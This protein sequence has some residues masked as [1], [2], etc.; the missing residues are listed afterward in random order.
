[1]PVTVKTLPLKGT[2]GIPSVGLGTWQ[3]EKGAVKKAVAY[4]ELAFP[5]FSSFSRERCMC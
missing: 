5:L 3:S 1:M 2:I 4:G